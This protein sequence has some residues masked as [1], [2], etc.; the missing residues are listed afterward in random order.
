MFFWI[1]QISIFSILFIFLVHH[2]I[3]YFTATLTVPKIKD[4]VN[5]PSKKYEEMFSVIYK[6]KEPDL[7]L[8]PS[9]SD[10]EEKIN[11]KLEL[12]NFIKEKMQDTRFEPS[13]M[14]SSFAFQSIS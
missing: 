12:K 5:K 9:F 7:V 1:L 3:T 13:S 14:E 8:P 4:L 2:L 11:M 10:S 6:E